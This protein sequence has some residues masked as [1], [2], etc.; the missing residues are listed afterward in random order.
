[1][2]NTAQYELIK[3]LRAWGENDL[4]DRLIDVLI[5]HKLNSVTDEEAFR[6]EAAVCH[7]NDVGVIDLKTLIQPFYKK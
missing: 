6:L 2:T 3:K 4:A 1:M 7:P 5:E